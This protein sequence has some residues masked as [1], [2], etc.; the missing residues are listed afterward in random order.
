MAD[1]KVFTIKI[2]GIE[3]AVK[4][5]ETLAQHLEELARQGKTIKVD[6][7]ASTKKNIDAVDASVEELNKDIKELN[8]QKLVIQVGDSTYEFNSLR[9][10]AKELSQQLAALRA[11]GQQ[12]TDTYRELA[13]AYAEVRAQM[14]SLNTELNR[15]A[16]PS[17]QLV[18]TI[19]VLQGFTAMATVG[20]GLKNLFGIDNDEI[21]EAIKKM[22]SLIG[23][24]EG[25]NK[26]QE[27]MEKQ[28]AFGKL[29]QSWNAPL[30]KF[31][32][33]FSKN[34]G[35][36]ATVNAELRDTQ[37]A[38]V[39]AQQGLVA[40]GDGAKTAA[41]G[42]NVMKTAART[43]WLFALIEAITLAVEWLGK[44]VKA[45]YNWAT[46]AEKTKAQ[47]EQVTRTMSRL[48]EETETFNRI[49]DRAEA[50]GLIS[51]LDA[52]NMK[53]EHTM[54]SIKE[55]TQ[56]VGGL[57]DELEKQD[58]THSLW[59]KMGF[60]DPELIKKWRKGFENLW[61]SLGIQKQKID[62]FELDIPKVEKQYEE[63]QRKV[64]KGEGS[65]TREILDSRRRM[66][67]ELAKMIDNTDF[68]DKASVEALQVFIAQSRLARDTIENLDDTLEGVKGGERYKEQIRSAM[69]LMPQ[70]ISQIDELDTRLKRMDDATKDN[71]IAAMADGMNKDLANIQ[72][73]REKALEEYGLLNKQETE[74][75]EEE[76]KLRNSI[77]ARFSREEFNLR[78]SWGDKIYSVQ[79]QI[80]DNLLSA[81]KKGYALRMEQLSN[82]MAD[83]MRAA[84]QNG[85]LTGELQISIQKKYNQLRIDEEKN[86]I[87]NIEA[88]QREQRRREQAY[89]EQY[90]QN[91]VKVQQDMVNSLFNT[92]SDLGRGN[93]AQQVVDHLIVTMEEEWEY[94][95]KEGVPFNMKAIF[96][97]WKKEA[98][99]MKGVGDLPLFTEQFFNNLYETLTE[100]DEYNRSLADRME[101]TYATLDE[102]IADHIYNAQKY[103]DEINNLIEQNEDYKAAQAQIFHDSPF[104]DYLNEEL[105]YINSSIILETKRLEVQ[106]QIQQSMIS[107]EQTRMDTLI[108]QQ[109]EDRLR[110][111]QE[112]FNIEFLEQKMEEG[113]QLSEEE[114]RDFTNYKELMTEE[115]RQRDEQIV[116]MHNEMYA[117]MLKVEQ[118]FAEQ[119]NSLRSKSINDQIKAFS[120]LT[121]YINEEISVWGTTIT[122]FGRFQDQF[123]QRI[124]S[125]GV[126]NLNK[127]YKEYKKIGA[128]I[129]N[130]I[131]TVDANIAQLKNDVGDNRELIK[132]LENTRKQL[133]KEAKVIN[134]EWVDMVFGVIGQ[135]KQMVD[136]TV[137]T[138]SNFLSTMN[139]TALTLI[140]NQ[141]A[142]IEHELEIQQEAYDKAEEAANKHKDKMNDIEDE[143]SE[144]RGARREFL[145]DQLAQQE[146][147]Y[148]KDLAAQQHAQEEKEK[149]EKKQEQLEK[150][151]REQEKKA[152]IQQ[153]II[154]TYTA[155]SNALAV[156]PWF[157]GLALSAVA[158][159]LGMANVAAISK[160]PIY[161]DGGVIQGKRHS[162]GGVKVLG[163]QA[164]VEGGEYITN[165][166]STRMNL[167]LLEYIN[168]RKKELDETDLLKF[169]SQDKTKVR[170]NKSARKFAQ[171]GQIQKMNTTNLRQEIERVVIAED[172]RPVVVSVVD[173]NNAQDNVRRVK[174]LSGLPE[175]W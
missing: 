140:D 2:N 77:I 86:Y 107:M 135:Y 163:G 57:Y 79:K 9:Q 61:V 17:A 128:D 143:L 160:T 1:T 38:G 22:T 95:T 96:D 145:V 89:I 58:V 4:A 31:F 14:S 139:E 172:E 136:A 39:Q 60:E 103:Q 106:K 26:I 55:L 122:T 43:F 56:G 88:L 161:K 157:L 69:E 27:A 35:T 8:K 104:L 74:M 21:D 131:A 114:L 66:A 154:N 117:K 100:F 30:D 54:A 148:L 124:F 10:A 134:Q 7:S 99:E 36:V 13:E 111:L 49:V 28:T 6:V 78:K 168:S 40:V 46:G 144:A 45:L 52:I 76:V 68:A 121:D 162:Q 153:A 3:Q 167:P 18:D 146:A 50:K 62:L 105:Q 164:E 166:T 23:V 48:K 75:T 33:I 29:I 119:S 34:K 155:V 127:A 41:V 82:A 115:E 118:D 159:G 64:R 91:A 149:L 165:R 51:T 67:A 72:R 59:T 71:S 11:S 150:K 84:Q 12:N 98:S 138:I 170:V 24:L 81:E 80:R 37:A 101:K 133:V 97:A 87:K 25:I 42:I 116:N 85:I 175:N 16:S 158:L 173:I 90:S 102:V 109:Y 129:T 123:L 83:E 152:N 110:A 113:K 126:T 171:G 63:L 70:F 169:F 93:M 73:N 137:S 130:A 125:T 112:Q 151:R 132:A 19:S 20:T 141:L 44:G 5:T 32:S 15:I 47:T 174:A 94:Q 156:Q 120:V 142:V 147:A 92:I 108:N 53:I 65:F